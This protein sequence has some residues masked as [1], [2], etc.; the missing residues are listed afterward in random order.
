MDATLSKRPKSQ[1][2]NLISYQLSV[3]SYQLSDLSFKFTG[4]CLLDGYTVPL[5]TLKKT[6]PL[7]HSPP[8]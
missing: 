3:I 6:S 4:Y 2:K 5:A 7:P 1:D 8:I